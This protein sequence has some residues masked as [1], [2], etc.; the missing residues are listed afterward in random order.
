MVTADIPDNAVTYAKLPNVA[1]PSLLGRSSS[2]GTG[3]VTELVVGQ[4]LVIASGTVYVA[5][6]GDSSGGVVG[7]TAYAIQS[8][9]ETATSNTLAVTP[10]RVIYS[11]YALK[12]SASFNGTGTP[13]FLSN[14]GFSSITDNG[15]GNWTLNFSG[16]MSSGNYSVHVSATAPGFGA[17]ARFPIYDT[18]GSTSVQVLYGEVQ[19]GGTYSALDRDEISVTVIGDM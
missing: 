10:G 4:A 12:K 15:T 7:C 8:D 6:A 1:S 17:S 18:T 2:I 14:V 5:S 16:N 11:P 13:A 9:M 3:N 19:S